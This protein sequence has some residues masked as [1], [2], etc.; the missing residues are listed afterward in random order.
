[1]D[2]IFDP[3]VWKVVGQA[4]KILEYPNTYK[5]VA[6]GL[7]QYEISLVGT[8]NTTEYPISLIYTEI[9]LF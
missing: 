6:L 9:R 8:R 7:I 2:R 1:M 5:R 3:E 4:L